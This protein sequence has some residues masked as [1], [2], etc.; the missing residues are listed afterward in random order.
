VIGTSN[1]SSRSIIDSL[2]C[3]RSS[4]TSIALCSKSAI[5]VLA[6][7]AL[8]RFL[9]GGFGRVGTVFEVVEAREGLD[10]GIGRFFRLGGIVKYST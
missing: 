2:K 1:G 10:F 3:G 7:E 6:L 5:G 8:I 9:G 4:E